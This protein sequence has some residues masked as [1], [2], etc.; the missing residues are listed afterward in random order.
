LPSLHRDLLLVSRLGEGLH[1]YLASTG[2]IRDVRP[3]NVRSVP[4]PLVPPRT[5]WSDKGMA[6]DPRTSAE[7]TDR[8]RSRGRSPASRHTDRR[9][10]SPRRTSSLG[11]PLDRS[12]A[13]CLAGPRPSPERDSEFRR[14]GN[15]AILNH[16]QGRHNQVAK[17]TVCKVFSLGFREFRRRSS[18]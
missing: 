3:S 15:R 7:P 16:F 9:V 2:L 12:G 17:A 10:I 8:S 11:D 14:T 6:S 18:K 13:T 1:I 5:G 4:V